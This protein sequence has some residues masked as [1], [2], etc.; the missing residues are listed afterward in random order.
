MVSW[1]VT[2]VALVASATQTPVTDPLPRTTRPIALHPQNGHYFLWRDRP[3][4]LVTSGEHYGA[5][6]NVDF[7]FIRY[8]DALKAD[9]LNHTRTFAG[10]YREIPDSFGITD[11]PLAPKPNRYICPW[12]RSD[13]PGY[14]DGG[15]RF[16]LTKWDDA[17]FTRLKRFMKAAQERGV[18][19]ELNLFCPLY[20]DAL[21]R[22][23][24]M[25][26]A[27]NIN[28]IGNCPRMEVL[29]LKHPALLDVQLALTRKIVSELNAFDNLYYEVCNEPYFGGVTMEWQHRIVDT[30]V[31]TE[32]KLTAKHLISMN[33][34]N[35]KAKVTS[36][37][38]AVSIF[39]FHY[40]V[41]PDT[42]A[43]NFG[44]NK[45]IGENETGFRG[46]EDVL[47][48]SEGWDFLLAGGGLY[49]NLDYSFTPGHPD[50]TFLEYRSPGGGSPELRKQLR[51]LKE[52]LES[53][54]FV[55]MK[56]DAGIVKRVSPTL[57]C[58]ALMEPGKAYAIY[59]HVPLPKQ[60]KKLGEHLHQGIEATLALELPPGNY[61][62]EW[63][64]TKTGKLVSQQ[65]IE[66]AG[67][68]RE[69]KSP[70]FDNDIAL[71][72][73]ASRKP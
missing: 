41:P 31:E 61:K 58:S 38:A 6:L 28:G 15:K 7:D 12:A 14:F 73:L 71:R 26:H 9:G 35:D 51:V 56:P 3:T 16:D 43:M 53:F 70:A 17:Y 22:A 20:D 67:D 42:V 21:W 49:N 24:P 72:L 34:A 25:Q 65:Q 23:S 4:I 46:K 40:C 50:G 64:D 5:V 2:S 57:T 68:D 36:P 59:L 66:H 60:L 10:T 30:I 47:Y 32:V 1:L 52:F 63:V 13:Q 11:N 39:N 18:V 54:D 62:I 45:V 29:T 69:L 33:I 55:R 8:L 27:N 44:L 37:H 19:V 48:R